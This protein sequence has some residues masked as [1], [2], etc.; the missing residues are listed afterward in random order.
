MVFT[1]GCAT[2][3][4]TAPAPP[5]GERRPFVHPGMLQNRAE[6]DFMR[7][8]VLAGQQPWKDAW[9]RLIRSRNS[10]LDFQPKPFAHVIRGAYNNPAIGSNEI[11]ASAAAAYSQAI[12]WYVTRDPAHARKAIEILD[13]WSG[14]LRDFSQNDAKLLAA[15]TGNDFLNAA[16][17]LRSTDSGWGGA[18]AEQFKAMMMNVYYPLLKN[19]FP[20]ANGN[21]D[22]AIMDT[23]LCMGVYFDDHAIFDRAVHHYL[24]GHLN[25]G[26]THY[27]YPSGQCQ[28]STRDQAHVQLGLGY[29][30]RACQVA[31]THGVDLYGAANNRL[32]LGFEYTA[33]YNLGQ[34]VPREGV[35]SSRA[36]GRLSDIY[37]LVLQHYQFDE[38]MSMPYTAQAAQRTLDKSQSVLTCYR[39]PATD[40]PVELKPP[41]VPSPIGAQGGAQDHPTAAKKGTFLFSGAGGGENRNVPFSAVR[42]AVGQSVQKAVDSLHGKG[43][44]VVL[45]T[46]VYELPATLRLAG[47]VT[48]AGQGAGTILWVD[49]KVTG[50][51]IVAAEP[52][53]QDVTLRDLVIEGRATLQAST[54]PN[55]DRRR[56][57][58]RDAPRRAGI[59]LQSDGGR[60]MR[61]LRFEH[62]TVRDC[63]DDG[64]AIENAAGVVIDSCSFT[65]NGNTAAD[66]PI[67]PNDLSLV[68]VSDC[69]VT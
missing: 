45:E 61:R 7:A 68:G 24:Y 69:Q 22:A 25:G 59:L 42:V 20:E 40:A 31:W 67:V 21:W 66:R 56:R 53:V 10:S 13:A 12:Q 30:A 19:F 34:D 26:I 41:P 57:T 2:G 49:P 5:A 65:D 48:L 64:L 46:G 60:P 1:E 35:I 51:A 44:W 58:R 43:G 8:K 27:V 15:W 39:G 28:E 62:V 38:H 29:M 55:A 4:E 6:L 54:D 63:T 36:R 33:K 14:T 52:G 37:Q 9:D 50:P 3:T 18:H 17:I 47:N 32:A 11:S 16:E 23:L